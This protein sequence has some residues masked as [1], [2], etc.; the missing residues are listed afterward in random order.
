MPTYNSVFRIDQDRPGGLSSG[1]PGI[2]RRD[3][4]LQRRIHLVPVSPP[5]LPGTRFLWEF[6]DKRPRSTVQ[7]MQEGVDV[8]NPEAKFV[9]F[10]PDQWGTYRVRLSIDNGEFTHTMLVA[11][12][13]DVDGNV[14]NRGWRIP[15]FREID[16]EGNFVEQERGYADDY[17]TIFSDILQNGFGGGPG[18]VVDGDLETSPTGLRVRGLYRQMLDATTCESPVVGS[19]LVFQDAHW[20]ATRL[21]MDMIDPAFNITAFGAMVSVV[22]VGAEIGVTEPPATFVA[23]YVPANPDSAILRDF[24]NDDVVLVDP[25]AFVSPNT[26]LRN[27]ILDSVTFR[28]L[29]TRNGRQVSR[30]MDIQWALNVYWGVGDAEGGGITEAFIKALQNQTLSGL[31]TR[32][33]EVVAGPTQRIYYAY[34]T[35]YGTATFWH[36]GIEGGFHPVGGELPTV[37]NVYGVPAFYQVYISDVVGLGAVTIDVQEA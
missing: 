29:A 25:T 14:I 28:L 3:L 21:S 10:E 33:I 22:E 34:P 17:D 16:T 18:G 1:L 30:D 32:T 12:L 7:F 27:Q 9:Y 11:V 2:S 26:Y 19:A 6:L 8:V 20:T 5:T 37:T 4:W 23:E 35:V 24:I 13:L 15:A 31:I 36:G